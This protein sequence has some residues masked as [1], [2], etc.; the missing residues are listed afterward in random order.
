MSNQ[1][2]LLLLSAAVEE[3]N[4]QEILIA[5]YA[6]RLRVAKRKHR[7]WIHPILNKRKEYG[8]FYHLVRELELDEE[9]YIE[10]FRMSPQQLDML[11]SYVGPL[12]TKQRAVREPI[13]AKQR[14][15]I[16]LR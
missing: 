14:L 3:A 12:I 5:A 1:F 11:L 9:K 2:K 8:A 6:K 7:F 15:A 16:C 4:F 13:D 10:Y